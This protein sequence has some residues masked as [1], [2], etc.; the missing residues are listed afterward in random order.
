MVPQVV[1]GI[2]PGVYP[3]SSLIVCFS[4][5]AAAPVASADLAA[6]E[7]AR[8]KVGRDAEAHVRLALWCEAQG[9]AAE[10]TRHLAMAVILDPAN[11]RAR[12]LLGL[13]A[14][15]DR[16]QRPEAVREQV[17]ADVALSAT[18][19]E[20]NSRRDRMAH[21]ADAHWRLAL[22]CEDQGL[23]AEAKVHLATVVRMDPG[24][25]AAWKHL[26]CKK[27]NG[28]WMTEAEATAAK[29][30]A[31]A[32]SQADRKWRPLLLKLRTRLTE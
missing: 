32:Q 12:G 26:G 4:L 19:A 28:L 1:T 6:Y 24:R 2:H 20:Y 5:L 3:V 13:V 25:E 16:W 31:G 7:E 21:T 29:A 22:W 30:E 9:L 18:L 17:K 10:R 14:Y 27:Y 8:S 23:K 15:R 11:A